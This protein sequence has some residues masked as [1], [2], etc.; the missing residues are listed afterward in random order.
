MAGERPPEGRVVVYD[1]DGY[2][3]APGMAELLAGEG[4]EV[5]LVT[6]LDKVSPVSDDTLEG[7][8]LRQHLHDLGITFHTN[9]ALHRV[10]QGQ[11]VGRT[12]WGAPW[13]L[14]TQG[15][16]LVTQQ[17]SEDSLYRDLVADPDAVAEAGISGVH[18]IG[19]A[20]AP[21]M[22]SEAVFDGHR[23]GREIEDRD[24]M[25]PSAWLRERP[26]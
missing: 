26:A 24:P 12:S 11:V 9:V 3:V 13:S 2:F 14:G 4:H 23:L 22:P 7:E 18:V 6:H 10:E 19:D 17:R 5:H 20:V 8:M 1:T 25:T 16:V 15:T 21:R